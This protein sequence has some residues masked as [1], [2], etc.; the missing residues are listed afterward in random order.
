MSR[1]SAKNFTEKF[2]SD[3]DFLKSFYLKGGADKK[4]NN[5]EKNELLIKTAKDMGYDFTMEEYKEAISDHYK[6]MGF[7]AAI[8]SFMRIRKI[9]KVADKE[10]RK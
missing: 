9:S 2:F 8:K 1:E 3:D 5:E 7:W 4:A 10:K 6:G